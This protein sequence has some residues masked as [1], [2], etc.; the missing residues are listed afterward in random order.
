MWATTNANVLRFFDDIE[1]SRRIHIRYEDLVQDPA[2]VM[3]PKVCG[4]TWGYHSDPAVLTPYEG[5]A[6]EFDGVHEQSLGLNDPN[7]MQ[8]DRIDAGL[9]ECLED[10]PVAAVAEYRETQAEGGSGTWL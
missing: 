5:R 10:D 1:E 7:F 3:T 9:G 6:H 2:A 4:T 8:H